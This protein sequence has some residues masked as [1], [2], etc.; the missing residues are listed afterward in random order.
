VVFRLAI[1]AAAGL[2]ASPVDLVDRRPR[3]PFGFLLRH[4]ALCV[5]LL[6]MLCLTLLFVRVFFFAASRHGSPSLF[7]AG[8]KHDATQSL[9]RFRL[10]LDLVIVEHRFRIG[11]FRLTD[12][13]G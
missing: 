1:S 5:S 7:Q 10:Q 6:D 13:Y 2:L 4:T 9:D 8:G 3:A 11:A 12:A